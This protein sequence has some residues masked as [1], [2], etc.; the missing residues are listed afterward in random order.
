LLNTKAVEFE[1]LHSKALMLINRDQQIVKNQEEIV[2]LRHEIDIDI[3]E[4]E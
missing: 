2:R 4:T 1:D 3:L